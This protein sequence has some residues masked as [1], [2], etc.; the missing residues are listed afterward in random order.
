LNGK[1][2]FIKNILTDLSLKSSIFI[3]QDQVNANLLHKWHQLKKL[4]LVVDPSD[5]RE[6]VPH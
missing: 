6:A 2:Y 4:H 5:G 3:Y 1:D